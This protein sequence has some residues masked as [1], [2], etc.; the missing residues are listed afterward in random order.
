MGPIYSNKAVKE[1]AS[2]KKHKWQ[3]P[4]EPMTRQNRK[5]RLLILPTTLDSS[6]FQ[7]P[8]AFFFFL[9]FLVDV[10]TPWPVS[11]SRTWWPIMWK[12]INISTV[13]P[14]ICFQELRWFANPHLNFSSEKCTFI[15][16]LLPT[17]DK[18]GLNILMG[19]KS[20][21]KSLCRQRNRVFLAKNKN[22]K[23]WNV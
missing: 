9:F 6:C 21:L 2:V 4:W 17:V 5:L 7:I 14:E 11:K 1:E 16:T 18:N 15:N 23:V 19:K 10:G 8:L 3:K 22:G 20:I 12:A 13:G